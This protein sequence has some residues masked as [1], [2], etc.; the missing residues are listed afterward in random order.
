[1]EGNKGTSGEGCE[2]REQEGKEQERRD[3][4]RR[5]GK[6]GDRVGE[7]G[8]RKGWKERNE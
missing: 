3:E 4:R 6:V 2:E 7:G 5:N 1:M 8:R